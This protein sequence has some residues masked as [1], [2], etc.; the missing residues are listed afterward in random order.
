M[1]LMQKF[2]RSMPA[3]IIILIIMFVLLIVFEWGDAS[4]GSGKA[5]VGGNAIG[6]VNG[7][8]IS[9]LVFQKRENEM[10]DNQRQSNPDGDINTDQISDVVWQGLVDEAIVA[11]A[12]EDMGIFVSDEMVAEQLLFTPP[13][14]LKKMFTDTTSGT[15]FEQKYFEF[16]R[17]PRAWLRKNNPNYPVSEV[18]KLEDYL[19]QVSEA[20]RT[21]KLRGLVES[22]VASGTVP[23]PGEALSEYRDQRS[24]A[25]GTYALVDAASIADSTIAVSDDDARAYFESHKAEFVQKASRELKFVTF[26]FNPSNQDSSFTFKRLREVS[27]AL[28]RAT[29]AREKDSTFQQFADRYRNGSFEASKDVAVNDLSPELLS[30][31]QGAIPGTVIGP[32]QLPT[33]N[34]MVLVKD[35]HDSGE[36]VLKA[37]HILLRSD[38]NEDSI[39]TQAE[40]IAKRARGGESFEALA[41]Q[42]SADG[43]ASQGGDLG[44]FN[45]ARMVKPFSD[46][47][48]AADVGSIVGPVKTEFGYHI[49]RVNDRSSR[50]YRLV[51]IRFD[52]KVS[53]TTRNM[54]R[55]KA[56]KFR[57]LL[58]EGRSI[59]TLA[60]QEKLQVT[61]SG[62]ITRI[63]PVAGSPKLTSWAFL[64]RQGEVSEVVE[65]TGGSLVVAQLDKVA[66]E[67]QMSFEEAKDLVIAKI[68]ARRKLDMI[69]DRAV[70]L[71]SAL[72]PGDSL[73]K[74][75]ALDSTVQVRPFVDATRTGAFPGVGY[76]PALS[77]AVYNI[78]L[79]DISPLIRGDRGWFIVVVTSRTE[80]AETEFKK[81]EERFIQ[82]LVQQRRAQVANDWMS[83]M[84]ESAEIVDNRGR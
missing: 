68:R 76:D 36:T 4:R 17:D 47:A 16:M 35:V 49:I 41:Q 7:R 43:S 3:V 74:L 58:G 61:Q 37:Q 57:D 33:G 23:S 31:L 8:D 54:I 24:K 64:A 45:R 66:A 28:A 82:T 48:F 70:K 52:I 71:R 69:K 78:K 75:V 65:Q 55:Q 27:E 18:E 19:I 20:V 32:I 50:V 56:Q 51:D 15:Y 38:G 60:A 26:T 67:G 40:S 62:P 72:Q 59:D 29:T 2:R 81:E 10:I 13:E 22:V 39:R 63:Q 84:R 25:S 21:E 14:N 1:A 77:S 46:A 83:R 34:S 53:N 6:T 9:A 12:A 44:Y 11:S 30:A 5:R 80:P 79:N 73:S 42:Y